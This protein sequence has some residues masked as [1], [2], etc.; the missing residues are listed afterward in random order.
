MAV[1]K[2]AP[3]EGA[4]DWNE[5]QEYECIGLGWMQLPNYTTFH[6]QPEILLALRRAYRNE[7]RG[8]GLG[9]ARS[10]WWF[11]DQVDVD[12]IVIAN[13]G[14]SRVV[15]IGMV[16]SGYLSP[17]S[18][19]N[20]IPCPQ[21]DSDD[22]WRRHARRVDWRISDPVDLPDTY[23]FGI[24]T[25]TRL[26]PARVGEIRQAYCNAYPRLR[27]AVNQLLG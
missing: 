24:N 20:P 21:R 14:R 25:V 7:P 17:G 13:H 23:F 5:C 27:G 16:T 15:G 9:A 3:G 12:D 18:R 11:V 2:I 26:T 10:I 1:W 19:D 4:E 6:H 22:M 8:C